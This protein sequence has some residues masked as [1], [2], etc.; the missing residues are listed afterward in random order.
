MKHF[1]RNLHSDYSLFLNKSL[2]S[3][4]FRLTHLSVRELD[5]KINTICT[6]NMKLHPGD[7]SLLKQRGN[8][9]L[10]S[11]LNTFFPSIVGFLRVQY[12][13]LPTFAS[14]NSG[15]Q[16]KWRTIILL[17]VGNVFRHSLK[18]NFLNVWLNKLDSQVQ[19]FRLLPELASCFTLFQI[20]VRS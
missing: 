11:Q 2:F 13:G 14:H 6:P 10:T 16:I 3:T 18:A 15:S 5:K 19:L 12:R 7:V 1:C 17:Y 20:F 4:C 9:K 8:H